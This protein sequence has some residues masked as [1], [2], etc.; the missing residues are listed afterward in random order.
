MKLS[1]GI[2]L[3]MILLFTGC[4]MKD[5]ATEK[6]GKEL[7]NA[8]QQLNSYIEQNEELKKINSQLTQEYNVLEG[9]FKNL[10]QEHNALVGKFNNLLQQNT[11]LEN[12]KKELSQ[13]LAGLSKEH[14]ELKNRFD[15]TST[16]LFGK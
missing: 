5:I 8:K 16:N 4:D 1:K 9:K 6:L 3:L 14:E 7:N 13:K 2:F 12:E 10:I 11:N 15:K